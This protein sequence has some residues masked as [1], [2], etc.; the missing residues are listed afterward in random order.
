MT[1]KSMQCG[2]KISYSAPGIRCKNRSTLRNSS[3]ARCYDH[4]GHHYFTEKW[5]GKKWVPIPE[6]TNE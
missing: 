4:A 5:D 3:E 1:D 6:G 2:Y